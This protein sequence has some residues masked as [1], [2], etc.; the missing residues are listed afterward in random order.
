LSRAPALE[1]SESLLPTPSGYAKR[2]TLPWAS[3]IFVAPL[4]VMYEVGTLYFTTAAQH[5]QDQQIIA[6]SKMG[7]FFRLFGATGRHMPALAVIVILLCTH[8]FR[9]DSWA[10]QLT[11]LAGMAAESL[12]LGLPLLGVAFL[13]N[14]YM[15]VIGLQSPQ[16]PSGG[17][18]SPMM[19]RLIMDIG[20]GVY[21]EFVFRFSLFALLS[22]L[23][24]DV[25]KIKDGQAYLLMV[26]TSAI[27]FS[28]YHY[29]S[30]T[31][32]FNWRVFAFRT[33]AGI[34][35]GI[36]FLCRGFGITAG[37]HCAYDIIITFW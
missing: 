21:E 15:P 30:P 12:V 1:Y 9:R 24:S 16:Q 25:M 17:V 26:V 19:D 10:V 3:L 2:S 13:L 29:W 4:I 36:I 5:G 20:A 31:E 22:A 34:Y 23:L 8:I 18:Q 33:V 7:D 6:F 35:F 32:Y 11:T 27:L 14:R 37:S 28:A